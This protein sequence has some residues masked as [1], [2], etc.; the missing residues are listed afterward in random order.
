MCGRLQTYNGTC[1]V[2]NACKYHLSMQAMDS[3]NKLA[4][5]N[6]H[7]FQLHQTHFKSLGLATSVNAPIFAVA[8]AKDVL[9]DVEEPDNAVCIS[10]LWH[11]TFAECVSCWK[12]CHACTQPTFAFTGTAHH[13]MLEVRRQHAECKDILAEK[14]H[15]QTMLYF[16]TEQGHHGITHG[17]YHDN[18]Y[19]AS[20]NP[21]NAMVHGGTRKRIHGSHVSTAERGENQTFGVKSHMLPSVQNLCSDVL[22]AQIE[23]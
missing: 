3:T 17:H 12:I 6:F 5:W 2:R 22:L 11:C 19:A 18:S 13:N 14:C 8:I 15:M 10:A 4:L 21:P 7:G 16:T 20:R 9:A 1:L 23:M